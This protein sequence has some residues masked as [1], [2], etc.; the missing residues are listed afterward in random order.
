VTKKRKAA[1]RQERRRVSPTAL[2]AATGALKLDDYANALVPALTRKA[3]L[4]SPLGKA[5]GDLIVNEPWHSWQLADCRIGGRTFL[6]GV[7]FE[8]ERLDMIQLYLQD[9]SFGTSWEDFSP[10][11]E[12]A[13]QV[14]QS[15]WLASQL[16][17]AG[18]RAP[19]DDERRFSWGVVGNYYDPH[20]MQWSIVISYGRK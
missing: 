16:T 5:A 11:K 7:F 18:T 13:R 17:S 14:A 6:M 12:K 1:T 9:P 2:D 19:H 10:E 20:N 3:F 8:G 15:R 4:A